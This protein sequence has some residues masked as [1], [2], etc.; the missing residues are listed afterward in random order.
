M[1][2][3]VKANLADKDGMAPV[4]EMTGKKVHAAWDKI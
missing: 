1:K 4:I 2:L 3:A